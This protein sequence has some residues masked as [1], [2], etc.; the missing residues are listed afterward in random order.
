V[1]SFLQQFQKTA[2]EQTGYRSSSDTDLFKVLVFLMRMCKSETNG[3]PRSRAF[4]GF[5]RER[6]RPPAVQAAAAEAS[7]IVI[8]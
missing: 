1:L 8:P 4:L 2:A 7:R 5:L 6:F 3:R